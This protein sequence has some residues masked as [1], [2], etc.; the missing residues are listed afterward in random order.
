[1]NRVEILERVKASILEDLDNGEVPASVVAFAD[2]HDY[3]DANEYLLAD[4][5]SLLGTLDD[6]NAVL[7]LVD[8]WLASRLNFTDS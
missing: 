6:C 8:A 5:G 4:D 1:M 2:L 3:V 7:P